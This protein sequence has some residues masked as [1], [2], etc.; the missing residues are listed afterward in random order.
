[1]EVPIKDR[2]N[3]SSMNFPK[4]EELSFRMVQG[5]RERELKRGI[6]VTSQRQG[7]IKRPPLN[8]LVDASTRY[9]PT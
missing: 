2:L 8:Q 7:A 4:R 6:L 3:C 1:M 5:A 9:K